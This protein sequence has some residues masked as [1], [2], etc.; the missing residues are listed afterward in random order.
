MYDDDLIMHSPES[1]EFSFDLAGLGTRSIA[2]LLD[3]LLQAG[4]LLLL[5]VTAILMGV[6]LGGLPGWMY[7]TGI[8]VLFLLKW[9]YFA[10]FEALSD[11]RT[12]GKRYMKIRVVTDR[13]GSIGPLEATIRNLIRYLDMLGP[14]AIAMFVSS[15]WKRLGDYAAGTVVVKEGA[16]DVDLLNVPDAPEPAAASAGSLPSVSLSDAEYELLAGFMARR[17]NLDAAT[18]T[19]LAGRI[20]SSLAEKARGLATSD[21]VSDAPENVLDHL[22]AKCQR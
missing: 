5:L 2:L 4:V 9:G 3:L 18:R 21:V 16:V 12:P 7:I 6:N 15:K 11:G 17:D 8:T 1:V 20:A 19:Q 22:W 13:G 10:L 14:G